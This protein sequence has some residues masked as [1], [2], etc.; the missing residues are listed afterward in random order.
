MSYV[1]MLRL[2]RFSIKG[3]GSMKF[4]WINSATMN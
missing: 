4:L 2:D 3:L 1:N